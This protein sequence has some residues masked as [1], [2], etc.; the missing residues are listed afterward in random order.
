MI[1]FFVN[2]FYLISFTLISDWVM[3]HSINQTI[4]INIY[5][6][7]VPN[8]WTAVP[9]LLIFLGFFIIYNRFLSFLRFL[10]CIRL[11][12]VFFCPIRISYYM[13]YIDT[14]HIYW[15][16]IVGERK[17]WV[18]SKNPWV[19][20]KRK[21]KKR[22]IKSIINNLYNHQFY[23]YNININISLIESF[24]NIKNYGLFN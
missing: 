18:R 8:D 9:L 21:K 3:S 16:I 11:I 4:Y 23:I 10:V 1:C 14:K 22:R 7:V 19:R 17:K 20:R 15:Y 6:R 24:I 2:S 13:S 5:V 12:W